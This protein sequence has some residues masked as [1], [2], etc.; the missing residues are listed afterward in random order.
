M[1]FFLCELFD[2]PRTTD[3]ENLETLINLKEA[4]LYYDLI[5]KHPRIIFNL[6]FIKVWTIVFGVAPSK[7]VTH[8]A[9]TLKLKDGWSIESLLDFIKEETFCKLVPSIFQTRI[10]TARTKVRAYLFQ[11]KDDAS[12][13][14]AEIIKKFILGMRPSSRVQDTSRSLYSIFKDLCDQDVPVF[15]LQ[16][17]S[18]IDTHNLYR[19]NVYTGT[20]L[21]MDHAT[22]EY[23]KDFHALTPLDCIRYVITYDHYFFRMV[24]GNA[25]VVGFSS[26]DHLSELRSVCIEAI[27]QHL[28]DQ[29]VITVFGD[30]PLKMTHIHF[31]DMQ[32]VSVYANDPANFL[33]AV[34]SVF[35][36]VIWLMDAAPTQVFIDKSMGVDSTVIISHNVQTLKHPDL[37]QHRKLL[38]CD[39]AESLSAATQGEL[40]GARTYYV[41]PA[42]KAQSGED[43][44]VVFNR[45]YIVDVLA[46]HL[47]YPCPFNSTNSRKYSQSVLQASNSLV[48]TDAISGLLAKRQVCVP[49]KMDITEKNTKCVIVF[50]NRKNFM[51][52]VSVALTFDSLGDHRCMWDFVFVG[53]AE[54]V[55]YMNERCP[56]LAHAIVDERLCMQRFN[57]EVYNEMLKDAEIWTQ[58]L[59][60]GYENALVIQDDGMLLRRGAHEL[61][62]DNDWEYVGA[63][64]LPCEGNTNTLRIPDISNPNYVGNGG[65]SY[66]NIRTM[67]EICESFHEDKTLLFNKAL[68]PLPEDIYFGRCIWKRKGKLPTFDEAKIFAMEQ[69]FAIEALGVHK[70]WMYQPLNLIVKYLQSLF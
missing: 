68:Q 54:S 61:L 19:R 15:Y 33:H 23:I 50:D 17:R 40:D 63:P 12:F 8:R 11:L 3:I 7:I 21:D 58:L 39:S 32:H 35:N 13:V 1:D 57:I 28:K 62:T 47:K 67:A 34:P 25:C 48:F 66:R 4:V 14:K 2:T 18:N 44:L 26:R 56:N 37:Q 69:T 6:A 55:A 31:L 36:N 41:L 29:T 49:P 52:V 46:Q 9:S 70:F 20:I 27:N 51:N 38:V 30:S 45:E 60:R 10:E 64:W 24:L 59:D 5:Y 65:L 22:V 43:S 42:P 16:H 53:S